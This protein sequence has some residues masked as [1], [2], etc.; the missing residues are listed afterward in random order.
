M[1]IKKKPL[2]ITEQWRRDSI[3]MMEMAGECDRETDGSCTARN[4]C[5]IVGLAKQHVN[6]LLPVISTRW[7]VKSD[8]R[9]DLSRELSNRQFKAIQNGTARALSGQGTA[10]AV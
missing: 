1:N 6:I 10:K 5:P 9:L 3:G 2:K 7:V 8:T 4:L